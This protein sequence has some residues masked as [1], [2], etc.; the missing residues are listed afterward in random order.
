VILADCEDIPI[1]AVSVIAWLVVTVC[2]CMPLNVNVVCPAGTTT[3]AGNETN[4]AEAE[5]TDRDTGSPATGAGSDIVT[6]LLIGLPPTT[7]VGVTE[8]PVTVHPCAI[9]RA[10]VAVSV[11]APL[12]PVTT[13][14]AGPIAAAGAAVSVRML[15]VGDDVG[16]KDAVTPVG[17]PLTLNDTL[18]LK[19][20]VVLTAIVDVVLLACFSVM[21]F[22]AAAIV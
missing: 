8:K 22:G 6:V 16:L 7:V 3:E 20:P 4:A 11:S 14:V 9:V 13:I 17:K 19:P 10:M 2:V 5:G 12:V 18:L 21:A 15:D 1:V